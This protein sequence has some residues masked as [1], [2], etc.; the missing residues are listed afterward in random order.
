MV[1]M[2]RPEVAP[3]CGGIDGN[4]PSVGCWIWRGSAFDTV[5]SVLAISYLSLE[6]LTYPA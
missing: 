6:R 5:S 3:Y 1:F 2:S 4:S